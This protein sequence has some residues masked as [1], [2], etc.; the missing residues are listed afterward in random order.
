MAAASI[1]AASAVAVSGAAATASDTVNPAILS[2]V[3]TILGALIAQGAALLIAHMNR[4]AEQKKDAVRRAFDSAG[5]HIAKVTFDRYVEFCEKY[6]HLWSDAL[7]DLIQ[8]GPSDTALRHAHEVIRLRQQWILWVPPD[9]DN[10]LMAYEDALLDIG[11]YARLYERTQTG[12]GHDV[13]NFL[14]TMYR[15]FSELTGIGEYNGEKLD[16]KMRVQGMMVQLRTT[17]GTDSYNR[18]RGITMRLALKDIEDFEK[19]SKQ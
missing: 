1:I 3:G 7:S 19:D 14:D 18:L 17:L 10:T 8:E 16:D 13:E 12:T 5:S 9:I 6:V 4:R 2:F 11:R 15:R